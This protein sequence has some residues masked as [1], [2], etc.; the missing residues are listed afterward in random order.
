M[1]E[2]LSHLRDHIEIIA[3]HE[4]EFLARR[5]R[6]E[7]VGDALGS[8]IGSLK[9]VVIHVCMFSAW[10]LFN[11][12]RLGVPHFDPFPYPLLDLCVALEAIFLASFIV[13]R[14]S[15]QGRRSDERNHL[16]LQILMLTEREI[17]AVLGVERQLADRLGLKKV[18]TDAE[19]EQL[20]QK[21]PIDELA[22][23]VK[24][25]ILEE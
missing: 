17:T 21:T 16:I 20:V 18:A 2:P 14:Q 1:A 5:T 22:Q 23:T 15:R 19:I 9:F 6:S 10:L 13:M 4:Q 8:F 7:R 11:T 24:E 3:K 25:E 12:L